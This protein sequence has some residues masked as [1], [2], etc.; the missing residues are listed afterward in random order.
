MFRYTGGMTGLMPRRVAG[1]MPRRMGVVHER[2]R[3][4]RWEVG[5]G[6]DWINA[7]RE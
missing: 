2:L 5:D 7:K 3:G 4:G 1:V 6:L